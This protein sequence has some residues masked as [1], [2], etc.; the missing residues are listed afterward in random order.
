MIGIIGALESEVNSL[1]NDLTDVNTKTISGITFYYGIFKDKK[2][3]IAKSGVGKVFAAMC[4]EAMILNFD[5]D[6]ILHIGIAGLLDDTMSLNGVAIASSVVQHDM[7]CSALGYPRGKILETDLIYF[8]CSKKLID[9]FSNIASKNGVEYKVGVIASGDLFVTSPETKKYI[10]DTFNAIACEM[11]GAATGQ[12]SYINNIDFIVIRSFSDNV[13]TA[14]KDDYFSDR[15]T[16]LVKA[17][18]S[19]PERKTC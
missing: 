17:Y 13:G 6:K 1:I 10:V 9:D 12:V 5:V 14:T 16:S 19:E 15:A 18:L 8:P 4:A 2:V 3:V 11:E 7:D